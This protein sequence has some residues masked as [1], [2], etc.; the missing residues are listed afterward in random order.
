MLTASRRSLAAMTAHVANVQ[1]G[2]NARDRFCTSEL[3]RSFHSWRPLLDQAQQI[4]TGRWLSRSRQRLHALRVLWTHADV[5]GD[6]ERGKVIA[7]R[8]PTC[9]HS[10]PSAAN[11]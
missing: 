11:I 6:I 7:L 4:R 3:R 5:R 1:R 9:P 10:N 8:E 2:I